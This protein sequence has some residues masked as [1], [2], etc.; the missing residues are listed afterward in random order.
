MKMTDTQLIPVLMLSHDSALWEHWRQVDKTRWLPA[1]GDTLADLD[2]WIKTQR[3][4]V[5]VDGSLPRLPAWTDPSWESRTRKA[6][7]IVASSR[8]SDAEASQALA[9]GCAGYLHAYSPAETF[10]RALDA[11][12]SG[13]IWMGRSLVSKLLREVNQRLPETSNW[14]AGLTAR[15]QQVAQRAAM[16]SSNQEIADALTISER[17]VRAHLSAIFEKMGVNDRLLL[18]LKVHGIN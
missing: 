12:Q 1:R 7:I 11:I 16:G 17:T 4:F 3:S 6:Q 5:I 18:A 13:A 2:R 15:E 14:T 10:N 9:A 8:P